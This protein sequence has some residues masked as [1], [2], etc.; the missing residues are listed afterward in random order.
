MNNLVRFGA[1]EADIA[2]GALRRGGTLV[3]IQDL[4]FRLL[5]ALLERPGELL[6]RAELTTQLW[7]SETFVD[8]AAGLNTAVAKLR[9]ALGDQADRPVYIET[10]P[11]RGYRFIGSIGDSAQTPAV[12]QTVNRTSR[13]R[14]VL[15]GL[16][17]AAV[18]AVLAGA[19]YRL[20]ATPEPVRIAVVLF[21][22]ETGD[23]RFGP[24]SQGLT[25]AVVTELTTESRLAVIGNAAV[26]R[27]ARP[28]RDIAKVRDALGADYIVIGQVQQLD[29]GTIVRAHL[30]RGRDQAHV[31]VNVVPRGNAG[32]AAFQAA[33]AGRVRSAV[34]A[35]AIPR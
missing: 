31:W 34:A 27:T 8:A 7:G 10:V 26:L 14:P 2:S 6:T 29:G 32:E 24:L 15:V 16:A 28:F 17:A 35:H 13:R 12:E 25:D 30:I 11:R 4:P 1:F 18:V 3:P 23:A 22:N 9:E 21:D 20:R 19:A 5:A 33:V